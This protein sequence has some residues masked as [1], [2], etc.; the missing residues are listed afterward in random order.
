MKNLKLLNDLILKEEQGYFVN[1]ISQR[2]Y[3][4]EFPR[5]LEKSEEENSKNPVLDEN[6]EI[7]KFKQILNFNNDP[8]NRK[9][10]NYIL[11]K[12]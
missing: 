4:F 12:K 1:L 9:L 2:Y 5:N 10:L 11:L 3:N 6:E 7:S 8:K